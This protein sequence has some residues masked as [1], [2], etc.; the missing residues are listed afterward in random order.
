MSSG[1]SRVKRAKAR[2][3]SQAGVSGGVVQG[4]TIPL[5]T[6]AL[7]AKHKVRREYLWRDRDME[8]KEVCFFRILITSSQQGQ[9]LDTAIIQHTVN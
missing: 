6:P 3:V 1:R 4:N 7:E 8:Q 5:K 9:Q 2:I